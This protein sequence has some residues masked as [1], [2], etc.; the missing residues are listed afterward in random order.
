MLVDYLAEKKSSD[1]TTSMRDEQQ[2]CQQLVDFMQQE[3]A[4]LIKNPQLNTAQY[5][6]TK[7]SEAASHPLPT[8]FMETE[9]F[10]S[11]ADELGKNSITTNYSTPYHSVSLNK[12]SEQRKPLATRAASVSIAMLLCSNPCS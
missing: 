7:H 9:M 11:H 4:A 2:E 8:V 5:I 3:K 12:L 6:V 10:F 1:R